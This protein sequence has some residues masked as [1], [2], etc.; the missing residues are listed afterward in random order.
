[1]TNEKKE[2]TAMKVNN[3]ETQKLQLLQYLPEFYQEKGPGKEF[4]ERFL[5][6]FATIINNY[7]RNHIRDPHLF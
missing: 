3:I 6:I 4:L 7:R 5:G 1:M 2:R